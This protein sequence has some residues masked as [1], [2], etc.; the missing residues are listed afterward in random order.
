MRRETGVRSRARI[1][2]NRPVK[3]L[4]CGGEI[5]TSSSQCPTCRTPLVGVRYPV[6]GRLGSLEV[7][8][9][10]GAWGMG[11]VYKARDTRLN[12]EVAIKVLPSEATS[13][14]EVWSRRHNASIVRSQTA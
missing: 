4:R 1:A 6:E 9:L 5:S 11:E 7:I 3:C 10:L 13:M 8:S 12:R 14:R 2:A